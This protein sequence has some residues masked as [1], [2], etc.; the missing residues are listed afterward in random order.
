MDGASE[1]VHA[2][3]IALGGRAALIRGPS[4]AGKSD[5]ALRCLATGPCSIA[6]D[7]V[8]LVADDQVLLK[9]VGSRLTASAPATIRGKLEV[10]GVGILI[11]PAVATADVVL[12]VELSR[13]RDLERMPDPAARTTI[14]GIELPILRLEPFEASAQAKLLIALASA[15][16]AAGPP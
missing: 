4:R 14:L 1:V 8:L 6:R 15:F 12:V 2:T 5:L 16:G 13:T 7:P 9:R 10:S 3:A 11:V